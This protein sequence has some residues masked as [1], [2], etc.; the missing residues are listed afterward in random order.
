MFLER[1]KKKPTNK[2]ELAKKPDLSVVGGLGGKVF[3]NTALEVK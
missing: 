1:E 2:F 3:K